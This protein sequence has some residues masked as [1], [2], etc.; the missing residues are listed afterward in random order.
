MGRSQAL[1]LIEGLQA[2]VALPQRLAGR[3]AEGREH[4]G[5]RGAA[6]R[7][8]HH[9]LFA[10]QRTDVGGLLRR[11]DAVL[12]QLAPALFGDPVGGPGG[13]EAQL[14][15][16]GRHPAL[17][18]FL[19]DVGGHHVHGGA[20]GVGGGDGHDRLTV[21][22]HVHATY[23]AQLHHADGRDLRVL[24]AVEEGEEVRQ[25]GHGIPIELD[26]IEALGSVIGDSHT[27]IGRAPKTIRTLTRT[28]ASSPCVSRPATNRW[29][30]HRSGSGRGWP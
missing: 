13:G 7:T 17:Q 5:V 2:G 28:G 20:A 14:Y 16:H 8:G 26:G 30:R 22:I 23:H 3:A 27:S 29:A 9:R 24:H 18:Q 4:H 12:L 25:V 11:G 10:L 1:E 19:L 6:L 15:L 21:R